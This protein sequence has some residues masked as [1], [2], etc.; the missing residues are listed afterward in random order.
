MY[1]LE[2]WNLGSI[3]VCERVAKWQALVILYNPVKS[4]SKSNV[5]TCMLQCET[6]GEGSGQDGS[7]CPLQTNYASV[8][9]VYIQES[10]TYHY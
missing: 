1:F 10:E 4:N 7:V 8:Y 3:N 2:W 5:F 9:F 6:G